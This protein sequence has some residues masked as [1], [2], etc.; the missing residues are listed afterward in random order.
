[1]ISRFTRSDVVRDWLRLAT[2]SCALGMVASCGGGGDKKQ[3]E[4]CDADAVNACG[5]GMVCA[6]QADGQNKCQIA[7]GAACDP[8][9]EDPNCR[10][11]SECRK[12]PD[13]AAEDAPENLCLVV[14]A[15]E[16]DPLAP[17]CADALTC[18]EL[19]DG[20]HACHAPLLVR[21]SVSNAVDRAALEGAHV[22]GLDAES[23]AVTDVSVSGADGSYEL[24]LPVVRDADGKPVAESYTLRASAQGFQAFPGGLRTALPLNSK[25]AVESG[26]A[27][28]LE[29]ALTEIT[30]IAL[31]DDGVSRHVV[32]GHLA[33]AEGSTSKEAMA[34]LAGVL[35][36]AEGDE[37]WTAI[38]DKQGAFSIF[39]VPAGSFELNGYAAGVAVDPENISVAGQDLSDVTLQAH[40][41]DLS[42]VSG[43]VQIVNP[44]DGN[45]TSVILV[46]ASTFN[47]S[48]LRGET[49]RGLRAPRSGD[50]SVTGAFSIAGVPDGD[51]V[52]LA[53]FENDQLVRDPDTNIAGTD[54]VHIT[55]SGGDLAVSESFKVTGALSVLGP[56]AEL[57]EAVSSAPTLRWADDSSEDWYEVRVYDAFG[58]EVWNDLKV[59][60]VSGAAEV[61]IKY[62]GPMELGMYYQFRVTSW[63]QPGNKKP[64]PISA[65]EDL[66]GVFYVTP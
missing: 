64:A 18:A 36:V 48:S 21:G 13:D 14:K 16:C 4:S 57:P 65:T 32:S 50:P 37:T 2:V 49:P 1:M 66:R 6:A 41:A 59:P 55:V 35:V 33:D 47:E 23:T 40:L 30:L 61:S 52:V 7:P 39:N 9:A 10:V 42:T 45:A 43:S 27:Y 19:E 22:I 28:V 24:E 53:A 60:S 12:K 58:E 63:R 8:D 17:F 44:G 29:G 25:D 5:E 38:T 62:G 34:A 51:Y 15:G 54:L 20:S 26:S 46:V 56:G 31:P 11:G 3:A